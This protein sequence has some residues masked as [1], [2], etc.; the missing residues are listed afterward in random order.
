MTNRETKVVVVAPTFQ[1]AIHISLCDQFKKYF[2]PEELALRSITTESDKQKELLMKALAQANPTALIAL[3]LRPDSDTVAAYI[4]AHVPI[5]LIDEETSY[6]S[7]ITTNNFMGGRIAGEYL[8]GKN[9]KKI[10]IVS[11]KTDVKGGYNAEQRVKGFKMALG[12]GGI[13]ISPECIIEVLHYSYEDGVEV[14]P[15]LLNNKVD[16]IFCAA[17]D[18]CATGLLAVATKKG[19]RIPEDV[20]IV[21]FDDLFIAQVSIPK[22][23]TI[24]Q[25]LEKIAEAAYKMAV[26]QR[27][28]ILHKPQKI[29]FNPE[30]VVRQSA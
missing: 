18:N 13:S 17:G 27:N 10:A 28:E 25:P 24:R 9:R 23:T 16:A 6:V 3:S 12:I 26:M 1:S 21:G 5:V 14:M 2:K 29:I 22:L 15:K 30:L 8:M 11:G 4:A 7:T 19:I 20:A